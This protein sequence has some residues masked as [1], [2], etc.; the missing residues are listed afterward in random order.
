SE[1]KRSVSDSICTGNCAK[2]SQRESYISRKLS[3]SPHTRSET[4]KNGLKTWNR[5]SRAVFF[6]SGGIKTCCSSKWSSFRTDSTTIARTHSPERWICAA[7]SVVGERI[8]KN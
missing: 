2:D 7:E 1:S 6:V 3:R 4:R 8:T 5:L